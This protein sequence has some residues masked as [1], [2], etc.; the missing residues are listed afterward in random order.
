MSEQRTQA[1]NMQCAITM[2]LYS[3]SL[4]LFSFTRREVY[5][6]MENRFLK[7]YMATAAEV[8]AC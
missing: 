5:L 4:I 6:L 8:A 1:T 3:V 2:K 7:I